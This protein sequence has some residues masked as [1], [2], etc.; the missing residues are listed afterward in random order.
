[1]KPS[2]IQLLQS[3][4]EKLC[5]EVNP[6]YQ[7]A[8]S[9]FISDTLVIQVKETIRSVSDFWTEKNPPPAPGVEKRTFVV[10]LGVRTDPEDRTVPYMFDLVCSGVV[11]CMPDRVHALTASEAARQYGLAMIYGA[12]REQLLTATSRMV[13]GGRLLPTVSF[14]EPP[15]STSQLDLPLKLEE[16]RKVNALND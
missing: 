4:F 5:V 2:P 13:H 14:M 9:D 10:T 11:A 15:A 6:T 7:D 8:G 3:N 16:T 1:M 12:M